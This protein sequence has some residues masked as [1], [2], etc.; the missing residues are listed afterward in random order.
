MTEFEKALYS[1]VGY[2][3]CGYFPQTGGAVNKRNIKLFTSEGVKVIHD[4]PSIDGDLVQA[5]QKSNKRYGQKAFIFAET[6]G[7][8]ICPDTGKGG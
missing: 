3:T 6:T 2:V 4:D 5:L 8:L 7:E 1:S